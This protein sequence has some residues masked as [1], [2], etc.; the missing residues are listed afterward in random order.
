MK[1]R[2]LS[3]RTKIILA[4]MTTVVLSVSALTAA[5]LWSARST[6]QATAQQHVQA[7]SEGYAKA[8]GDWVAAKTEVARAMEPLLA[9]EGAPLQAGLVQAQK[10]GGFDTAYVG[11]SDKRHAFSNPQNLP[12]DYDPTA[13]PWYQQ[14]R[15]AGRPVLTAP[16][17]DAGT[18]RLIVTFAVPVSRDGQLAGVAAGD[19]FIDGVVATV[20]AIRPSARSFAYLVDSQGRVIAHPDKA[21]TLKD[22]AAVAPGVDGAR[23]GR[24]LGSG[25]QE[26][27]QLPGGDYWL[28]ARQ[29]PHTD[30]SLVLAQHQ[31][32]ALAGVG[33]AARTALGLSAV[34]LTVTAAAIAAL[35]SLLLRRLTSLREA[36]Q[37]VASG[38]G[39]LTRRLDTRGDDELSHVGQSFNLFVSKIAA[40]LGSIRQTTDSVNTA[41]REIAHGNQDL[42]ERTEQTASELQQTASAMEQLTQAVQQTAAGAASAHQLADGATAA[43]RQGG[44]LVSQVVATMG[45][46]NGSSQRIADIIAVIDG[47]AF[48]TN[49]LALNA[50]VEAARAGEQGRGFAV[51]AGEVRGLAQRSAQA[52]REI[53]GLI[54]DSVERVGDGS[55]L[56]QEAGAAMEQ[57][58]QSVE[59][60]SQVIGEI[61]AATSHQ[62]GGI[63]RVSATVSHL[64]QMTQ[65]NSA[66]VEESAAAAASLREQAHALAGA[67]AGFKL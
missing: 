21:L 34:L 16:Y 5:N 42:S 28:S 63:G 33:A 65:Q 56:V 46:I 9:A 59:R 40:T 20:N 1:F 50:A 60:V 25:A 66:L 61:T 31:G 15:A 4:S 2:S 55:R 17:A 13:R 53:R 3:I 43:A 57:I 23:I 24:M 41:A 47:I 35:T 44:E 38:D 8:L 26:S 45:R 48:Q 49:I 58:V 27:V 14:A 36:M 37:E 64:D 18:G 54:H 29:V 51:V 52:A 6:A 12:A 30:W 39:D 7:L 62:S 22:A 67:V 10:S 11:W 32:D 19:I